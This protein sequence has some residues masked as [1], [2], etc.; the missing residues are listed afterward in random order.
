LSDDVFWLGNRRR[1]GDTRFRNERISLMMMRTSMIEG[2]GK[3]DPLLGDV[4]GEAI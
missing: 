4:Q 3:I 1:A 2:V